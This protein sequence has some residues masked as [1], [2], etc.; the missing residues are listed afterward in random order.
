MQLELLSTKLNVDMS[1]QYL[2]NDT[3]TQKFACRQDL[4][5]LWSTE[6][7][8]YMSWQNLAN[9]LSTNDFDCRQEL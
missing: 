1:R 8:V 5:E 6:Q 2:V 7:D 3:S 9:D 4:K